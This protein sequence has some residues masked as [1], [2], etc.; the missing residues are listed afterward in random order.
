MCAGY[1]TWHASVASGTIHPMRYVCVLAL[2]I[3]S[4]CF[5][6]IPSIQ[7]VVSAA[8]YSPV[9]APGTWVAI[10][11]TNLALSPTVVTSLPLPTQVGGVSV[12]MN[13]VATVF[14]PLRY[15]SPTQINA[16]IPFGPAGS[17]NFRVT[18]SAG[19][20]LDYPV[21]LNTF[22]PS[23]Y[24]T[25]SSGSGPAFAFDGS[26]KPVSA[27]G[28]Q[29]IILYASGLGPTNPAGDAAAGGSAAEPF[30]RVANSVRVLI[31][32]QA[33]QV[34]FA[35]LAPGL[36]GVYQLNVVPPPNP[37]DNSL[38]VSLVTLSAG[39]P[40]SGPTTLPVAV[41]GNATQV[42]GNIALL[43]PLKTT[44]LSYSALLTTASFSTAFDIVPG[45]KAFNLSASCPGGN[46][47]I[48]ISPANGTWTATLTVPSAL[49]RIGD[50][51]QFTSPNGAIIRVLDFA[52]GNLQFP[53]NVVPASRIDQASIASLNG[54]PLPNTSVPNSSFSYVTQGT[55][56]P[57]GHFV[58]DSSNLSD[59]SRFA[60]FATVPAPGNGTGV[61]TRRV[62]CS[63]SV[64]G[65]L[66][67]S[68]SATFR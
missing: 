38:V 50:F 45:A 60:G 23:I 35:G 14:L 10:F 16:I 65:M 15:V 33:A 55:I 40:T 12:T 56:P 49:T 53:G 29:A 63:L 44:L 21:S 64:D 37:A 24:T 11:G 31:G 9:V 58:I 20:S 51:S 43:Y 28:T 68:A 7:S 54:V 59:L 57:N 27:I 62:D 46:A 30:N 34:A 36:P 22:A 47:N 52:N 18:T 26:F 61:I 3:A 8:D 67:S 19:T 41:G 17:V 6:Q 5:A 2:L 66:V 25:N 1:R 48:L 32:G 39:T 4:S 13:G 42:T